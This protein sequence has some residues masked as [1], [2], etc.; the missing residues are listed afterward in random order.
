MLSAV[1]VILHFITHHELPHKKKKKKRAHG[2]A[3]AQVTHQEIQLTTKSDTYTWH[4]ASP[5]LKAITNAS[6]HD[7]LVTL[8]Y[9]INNVYNSST[10]QGNPCKNFHLCR[11]YSGKKA[12]PFIRKEWLKLFSLSS[13]TKQSD[14]R[15]LEEKECV[16]QS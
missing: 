13:Q 16:L 6:K 4:L 15:Q 5:Q 10:K 2:K 7:L 11:F 12:K 14:S 1:Y 8:D 3:T 9:F